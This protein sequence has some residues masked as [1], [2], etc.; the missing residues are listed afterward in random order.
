MR[1]LFRHR[2][3]LLLAS[4]VLLVAAA[5]APDP[6]TPEYWV[7]ALQSAKRP[8]ERVRVLDELR[9]SSHLTPALLPALH[10]QLGEQKAPEVKA[11][12][13]RT[14]AKLKDASSVEPLASAV[15]WN[16]TDSSAHRLNT[17]LAAALGDIGD[18]KAAPTLVRL[19]KSAD[20]F[21]RLQAMSSLGTIRAPEAVQPLLEV[22][23]NP[24]EEAMV[25]GRA[26]VALGEIGDART[27]G[28]LVRLLFEER[29]PARGRTSLYE[30]ASFALYRMG[31][32]SADALLP[33]LAGDD[34]GLSKW[35]SKHDV[36]AG[37]LYAKSAQVLGYL[38]DKRAEPALL[39]RLSY[40]SADERE[41]YFVRLT[42]A[43]ALGRLRS[44]AAAKPLSQMLGE[45]ELM[46]RDSYLRALSRIGHASVLP[47]LASTVAIGPFEA[48]SQVVSA[49]GFLGQGAQTELLKKEAALETDR[50]HKECAEVGNEG[51][52]KKLDDLVKR[53]LD[54]FERAIAQTETAARCA[55]DAACWAKAL[56]DANPGVKARAAL[57]VGRRGQAG[58]VEQLV[59]LMSDPLRDVRL[60][61]LISADWLSETDAGLKPL[62]AGR[63]TLEA[64]LAADKGKSEY[65]EPSEDLRRLIA[66]ANRG[67]KAN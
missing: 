29:G 17:D 31:K 45:P 35:A 52:C 55:T 12:L 18:A 44:E 20:N 34:A 24:R 49:L 6:A 58:A 14:L 48:R 3:L 2:G 63:Q 4:G 42:A 30:P 66:K 11:A 56:T 25:A 46:I 23:Q 19:L 62:R 47:S 40:E 39:S 43:D 65:V 28:T 9:K 7:K 61:A 33:V 36:S 38:L 10:A 37:A 53:R 59:R 57:E 50:T 54:V 21:V 15:N 60:A 22:A 32:P 26:I 41:K 5:C 13:A 67:A 16:A 8:Q 1:R 27:V 64:L 51:P